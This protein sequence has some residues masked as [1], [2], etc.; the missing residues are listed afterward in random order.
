MP[1]ASGEYDPWDILLR[2][3]ITNTSLDLR[4]KGLMKVSSKLWR[5][6]N[7]TVVDLSMN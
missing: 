5:Y 7:L 4:G 2:E 6:D 3:F 1:G